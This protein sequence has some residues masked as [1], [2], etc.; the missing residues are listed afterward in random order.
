MKVKSPLFHLKR[1]AVLVVLLLAAI[2]A[3]FYF[4]TL[5]Y[6]SDYAELTRKIV[7][8]LAYVIGGIILM[9]IVSIS[10]RQF[11]RRRYPL[12][13]PDNLQARKMH[14]KLRYLTVIINIVIGIIIIAMILRN[15]ESLQSF[16]T[17]LLASAGLLGIIVGFSAQKTLGNVLAGLQIAF[18]QPM[19]IDDVVIVEGEW[20]RIEEITLTYVV[21]KIWDQ[22]RLVLP[23]TYFIEKPFQNWTRTTSE[24]WGTVFLYTDFGFP[25]DDLRKEFKR[26]LDG[27]GLWDKNVHGIQVTE[28]SE[29]GM[30]IRALMSA[31]NAGD[32]WDLRCLVREK[33]L[34]YIRDKHPDYLPRTRAS[35][36][37]DGLEVMMNK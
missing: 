8:S 34:D 35:L 21:V 23:I 3:Y 12:K 18:T 20:G 33:F 5:K 15:F 6:L 30:T 13:G 19:R 10:V 4:P 31:K 22:R 24:I 28:S 27:T 11:L 32:A 17:G 1:N 29:S 9:R 16:S 7:L 36:E 26:I 25:V 2:G 14:T 37:N